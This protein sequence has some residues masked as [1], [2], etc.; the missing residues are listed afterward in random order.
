MGARYEKRTHPVFG[1]SYVVYDAAGE[2][3][4]TVWTLK[5][6]KHWA[7]RIDAL[8]GTPTLRELNPSAWEHLQAR[9]KAHADRVAE[10]RAQRQRANSDA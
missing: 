5:D 4:R 6:A 3:R 2:S 1:T 10:L 9:K 8:G 7:A